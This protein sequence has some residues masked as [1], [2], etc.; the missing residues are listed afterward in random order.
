MS[1]PRLTYRGYRLSLGAI[2]H[3]SIELKPLV[4][5][6]PIITASDRFRASATCGKRYPGTPPAPGHSVKG[7]LCGMY[8]YPDI[9]AAAKHVAGARYNTYGSVA[10]WPILAVVAQWGQIL[11][12]ENVVRSEYIQVM[13]L[14]EPWPTEGVYDPIRMECPEPAHMLWY[15]NQRA[16]LV[17]SCRESGLP[18]LYFDREKW[19]DP[20]WVREWAANRNLIPQIDMVEA[21]RLLGD[22]AS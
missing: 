7:C 20:V 19:L 21:D 4:F 16:Q 18:L 12:Y 17:R 10:G 9:D 15:E 11:Q 13:G 6:R 8:A 22:I 1:R 2:K 5:A 3:D 14:F